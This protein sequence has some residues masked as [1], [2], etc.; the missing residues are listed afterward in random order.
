MF[1]SEIYNKMQGNA[2]FLYFFVFS[3]LTNLIWKAK[4]LFFCDFNSV[5]NFIFNF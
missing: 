2:S 5:N 4:S 1:V 3:L